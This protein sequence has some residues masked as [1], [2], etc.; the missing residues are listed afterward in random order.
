MLERMVVAVPGHFGPW[1]EE[2]LLALAAGP[3]RYE[4]LEGA[5]IVNPPP[6]GRHQLLAQRMVRLLHEAAPAG[7]DAVEAMGVRIRSGTL[8]IPDVVVARTDALVAADAGVLAA[9]DV[10]LVVEVVSPSSQTQDRIT[11][12]TLYAEAGLAA[13]WRVEPAAGPVVHAFRL[14]GDVYT[15]AGSAG[16]HGTLVLTEPF[17]IS[18]DPAQL[19]L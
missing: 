3:E 16:P 12:P 18:L 1:T 4:L 15:E 6:A 7:F 19:H 2:D 17:P 8:L 9:V 13:Y 14:V 10:L 5:L 11:K